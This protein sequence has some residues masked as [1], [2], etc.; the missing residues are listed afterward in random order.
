M[1]PHQ[2]T[3]ATAGIASMLLGTSVAAQT[4]PAPANNSIFNA[5][6]CVEDQVQTFAT[7]R[8]ETLIDA[9]NEP[10]LSARFPNYDEGTSPG[11]FRLDVRGLPAIVRYERDSTSLL[12]SVPSLGIEERFDGATRSISNDLFEDYIKQRG[13][14]ILRELLRVSPI[15]PL[16]G[17]PASLQSQM[18]ADEFSAGTD[19]MFDTLAPGHSFGLGARFGLYNADRFTKNVFTLPISYTYTFSNHDRLILRAPLTYMEVAGAE[20]Y[21]AALGLSYKRTMSPRWALTPALGYGVTGSL[22]LG[23]LGHIVS[24]SLTSDYL[25]HDSDR[26][27]LSMGNMLGYYFSLPIR[28]HDWDIDYSLE[29]LITRH[30]LLF[31]RPLPARF[32]GREWSLDLFA[33]G[34]WLFGDDLYTQDYL[35]VGFALGPRRSSNRRAPNVASNAIGIGLKYTYAGSDFDGV[36]LN[37]GY[38]F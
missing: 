36:E 18:V 22:D 19:A 1:S 23:S 9:V 4:C 16:A 3:T 24:T 29:N 37:F 8:L 33:T 11:E 10:F 14:R 12:F 15:D 2:L 27:T 26:F 32:L 17:N 38:R 30:G 5:T 34:T 35:E 13:D 7:N 6:L 25:L 20:T 31:S 21:R 28:I